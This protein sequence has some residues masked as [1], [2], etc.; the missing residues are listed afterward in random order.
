MERDQVGEGA[1][2]KR[3]SAI[4]VGGPLSGYLGAKQEITAIHSETLL[5]LF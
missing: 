3:K 5:L 2:L 4:Q 1:V